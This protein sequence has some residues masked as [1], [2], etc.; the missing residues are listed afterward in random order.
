MPLVVAFAGKIGSGKTTITK[1]LAEALGW[2]RTGFGDYVRKVVREQGLA[3]TREN[4]QR[5]GTEM[6]R[7]DV[8]NFCKSV[9]SNGG[10]Q[11][12][13]NLIIDGLRH[14]ETIEVIRKAVRPADL[15]TVYI[16]V[17]EKAR[18]ARLRQRGDG[19]EGTISN[20]ER[21]SSEQQVDSILRSRVDLLVEGS[22]PVEAIVAELAEW[23]RTQ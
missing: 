10:W 19:D 13:E 18:L 23:V 21:H 4:L 7:R 12:G 1:S 5:V 16:Y 20:V 17:P 14:V 9:L 15:R 8:N 3:S 11:P 6:L 2:S 22:R